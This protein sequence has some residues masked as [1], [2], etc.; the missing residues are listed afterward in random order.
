LIQFLFTKRK[1]FDKEKEL[2][3]VLQCHDPV[4]GM[5]RHFSADNFPNRE[6]LAENPIHPWV[7]CSKRRRIDLKSVVTE[8]RSSPWTT[9]EEIEEVRVWAKMFS[10]PVNASEITNP[11]TLTAEEFRKYGPQV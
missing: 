5:N 2:R 7:H 8:I 10:C 11:L 9:D 3:I 4:A 1:C 6:P